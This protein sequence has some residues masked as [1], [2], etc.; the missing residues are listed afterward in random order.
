MV[1][2]SLV[3]EVLASASSASVRL[4]LPLLAG[5]LAAMAR[6]VVCTERVLLMVRSVVPLTM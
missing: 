4:N 3:V 1:P 5:S 6:L 2:I